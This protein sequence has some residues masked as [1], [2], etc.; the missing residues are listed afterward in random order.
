MDNIINIALIAGNRPN[1]MMIA[2][3]VHAIQKAQN[4]WQNTQSVLV[5]TEQHYYKK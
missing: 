5:H 3:I 2:P 4:T 1:F